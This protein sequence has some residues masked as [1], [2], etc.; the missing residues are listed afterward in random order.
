VIKREI[1]KGYSAEEVEMSLRQQE[2]IIGMIID[3]ETIK[4]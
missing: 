2:E 4:L 3:R 1:M